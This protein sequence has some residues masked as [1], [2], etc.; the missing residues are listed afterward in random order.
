MVAICC[1]YT[2]FSEL[3]PLLAVGVI[4]LLKIKK[5]SQSIDSKSSTIVNAAALSSPFATF[6]FS[7]SAS[8]EVQTPSRIKVPCFK[9][10][11]RVS[12]TFIFMHMN[13]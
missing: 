5:I 3:L 9:F 4:P 13:L 11:A 6:S 7:A 12:V 1:R 10:P 2:A 8:F